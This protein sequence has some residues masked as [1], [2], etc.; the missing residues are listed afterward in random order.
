M[1]CALVVL[2]LVG[3]RSEPE[4]P[5]PPPTPKVEPAPEPPKPPSRIVLGDCAAPGTIFV[6][7]PRPEAFVTEG[8]GFDV[9][10]GTGVGGTGIG[11]IGGIRGSGYGGRS[12]LALITMGQP[13]IVGN[14]DK[15][16]VRG[17]VRRHSSKIQYCYEKELNAKPKLKGTVNASFTISSIGA[18]HDAKADGVDPRVADCVRAVLSTIQFPSAKGGGSSKVEIVFTYEPPAAGVVAP[19]PPKPPKPPNPPPKPPVKQPPPP[20]YVPGEQNPLAGLAIGPCFT[21]PYGV[22]VVDFTYDDA[23]A[24]TE[25]KVHGLDD[26]AA[27]CLAGVAKTAK[28][29]GT[30]PAERC[31]L[32]FGTLP[33]PEAPGVRMTH[34][35]IELVAPGKSASIDTQTVVDA[36]DNNPLEKFAEPLRV[37]PTDPV[38]IQ[39]PLVVR[40]ISTMK[41]K[42]LNRLLAVAYRSAHH[43]VLLGE[44]VPAEIEL[45]VVPVPID[46]GRSW[47]DHVPTR[48]ELAHAP[49]A[50]AGV[51]ITPTSILVGTSHADWVEISGRDWAKVRAELA[52]RFEHHDDLQVAVHDDVTIAEL[53]ALVDIVVEQK[54]AK[55]RLVEA[56]SLAALRT[57]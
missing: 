18:V 38:S 9:G 54:W 36:S 28:R 51:H 3:C 17:V 12:S 4:K 15:A 21:K 42:A 13:K 53:V 6:S 55:W 7:G 19:A 56:A 5:A 31:S 50:R 27:S 41:A 16:I 1:R 48:E 46:S 24:V 37:R 34:D 2:L 57:W 47:T 43:D 11:S 22:A 45:P 52:R 25:A 33:I 23:G 29:R 40:T 10:T 30:A 39:G 20:P 26:R 8:F 49:T 14:I 44:R 35:L 32:A